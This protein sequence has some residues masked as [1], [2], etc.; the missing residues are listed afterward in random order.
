MMRWQLI[1]SDE[2]LQRLLEQHQSCEVVIVDTEFM[3]RNTF[4]PEVALVQLCFVSEESDI[5]IAWLI[6]PLCIDNPAPL[7]DL[8][9]NPAV[10][11]VLHSVSEDLEVFQRWLNVLPQPLF[12]TQRAAALLNRGFGLG[13]RTLV[14]DICAI[15]LPKGETQSN[16]LQRP[17]SAAQCEYAGLDVT[18][19]LPVWRELHEQC[20]RQE[21]L[22]WVLGD[23]QDAIRAL[24]T[25]M[26]DS[27]RRIKTAWKLNQRE[28]GALVAVCRWREETARSRN[29]PRSWIIDDAACLL[30][31]Q[32]GPQT[33]AQL[34][35]EVGLPAPAV[36]RY[37]DALLALLE[38][39]RAVPENE[40]PSALPRPL[41]AA[42]RRQVK[43]LKSKVREIAEEL[44]VA[45]EVLVP[46]KDYELLLREA[47]GES[48]KSP[49]HWQGWRD[50]LVLAPL[51][52]SLAGADI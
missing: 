11:K 14:Q 36:R 33:L 37:G 21:K 40:L 6:D 10:L 16:W 44:A 46:G 49:A 24:G 27:H 17:L 45:P 26:T 52:Q 15:D 18:W 30:L 5:D 31:A 20:V 43:M 9:S 38:T 51:R 41:D 12:D 34:S 4:Y 28:L 35:D 42:Q 50:T 25:E 29:K 23:G 19:L 22:D 39:Q 3:R 32:K 48:V 13:Y 8:L 1:E 47:A 2:A 7:A